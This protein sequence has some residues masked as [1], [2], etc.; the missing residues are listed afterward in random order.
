MVQ[1]ADGCEF[2]IEGINE[3]SFERYLEIYQKSTSKM[4]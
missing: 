4:K 3:R 1:Y 2:T